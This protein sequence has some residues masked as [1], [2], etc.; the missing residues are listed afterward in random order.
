[1]CPWNL[2]SSAHSRPPSRLLCTQWRLHRN[3]RICPPY[4]SWQRLLLGSVIGL[5]LILIAFVVLPG[6]ALAK[7]SPRALH[8]SALL[9]P[10]VYGVNLVYVSG[11]PVNEEPGWR[12][13]ALPRLQA[14]FNPVVGSILLGLLWAGWH[15]PLFLVHGWVNVPVWAFAVIVIAAS[16]LFT[17]GANLSAFSVIVPMLMHA[18][19]NTSS[20]LFGAL[21]QGV[22]TREPDLPF[23]LGAGGPQPSRPFY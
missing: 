17:C 18:T 21:C 8:W 19:F 20:R 12:G 2:S 15:L 22:P 11:W 6:I 14:R 13:F 3:V 23:F 1:M 9:T 4:S 7:V 16:V 10:S 5:A